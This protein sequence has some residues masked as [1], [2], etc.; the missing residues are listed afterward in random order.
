MY[1]VFVNLLELAVLSF[2][3]HVMRVDSNH[4]FQKL[5]IGALFTN[6]ATNS[7]TTATITTTAT[8]TTSSTI[9][10]DATITPSDA[11]ITDI[12][13]TSTITTTDIYTTTALLHSS[14]K[15]VMNSSKIWT[16]ITLLL[17]YHCVIV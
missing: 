6:F 2:H 16:Q 17:V 11:N 3:G 4:S 5:Q 15:L 1:F 13:A 14:E 12:S 8:F 7:T 9:A 10:T